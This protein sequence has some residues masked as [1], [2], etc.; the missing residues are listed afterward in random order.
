MQFPFYP[1]DFLQT[2]I[3]LLQQVAENLFS[4]I[5]FFDNVF[6][7][8]CFP[9]KLFSAHKIVKLCKLSNMT[10]IQC[11]VM[12]NKYLRSEINKAKGDNNN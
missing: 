6:H 10:S 8:D 12:L 11:A 4:I 3:P 5:I 2:N 7:L 9:I 1:K